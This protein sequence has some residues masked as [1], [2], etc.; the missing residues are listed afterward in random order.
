MVEN[1][2]LLAR[3]RERRRGS[4]VGADAR[5]VEEVWGVSV[6]VGLDSRANEVAIF[7]AVKTPDPHRKDDRLLGRGVIGE[8]TAGSWEHGELPPCV[9]AEKVR[10]WLEAASPLGSQVKATVTLEK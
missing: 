1:P 10:L 7:V 2:Q 8:R 4:A 3:G 5:W 9:S 6:F